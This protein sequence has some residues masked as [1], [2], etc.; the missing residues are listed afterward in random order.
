MAERYSR[1]FALPTNLYSEGSPV[2]IEAGA[3]LRDNVTGGVLAQL[4]FFSFSSKVIKAMTVGI[5]PCDIAGRR[6]SDAVMHQ[7]LDMNFGRDSEFGQ[8]NAIALPNP[9]TRSFKVYVSEAVF[10]DNSIYSAPECEWTPLNVAQAPV[11]HTVLNSDPEL[12]KQFR[13]TYDQQCTYNYVPKKERDLWFCSCQ[14]INRSSEAVCHK[15]GHK[16]LPLESI[17]I[18]ALKAARDK[19]VAEERRQAEEAAAEAER[20]RR[21]EEA[22]AREAARLAAE[23][24]KKITKRVSIITSAV[25]LVAFLVYATGWHLI[26]YIKYTNAVKAMEA[27][28]YDEAY[29]AFIALG[30]FSDSAMKAR[31]TLYKKGTSLMDSGAYAEAAAEFERIPLYKDSNDKA[32]YCRNQAAYLEAKALKDSGEYKKAADIFTSLGDY[33][34][35]KALAKESNYLY[36]DSLLNSGKYE[37]AYSAFCALGAFKKGVNVVYKDSTTKAQEAKYRYGLACFESGDYKNAVE[38]FELVGDYKEAPAKLLEA[39]YLYADNLV[40]NSDLIK[41]S[42]LYRELGD[43]KDSAELYKK[44]YYQYGLNL[45][46]KEKNYKDAVIVFSSLGN[47]EE[48]KSKLKEAKYGYVLAHKNNSDRLTYKY[49]EEL[50]DAKYKDSKE[51]YKSLYA[52]SVK[53]VAFNTDENDYKTILSSVSRKTK[54]LHFEFVIQGGPP[55]QTITLTHK[56]YWP[57]GSTRTSKWYWENERR[58]NTIGAYWD[59]GFYTGTGTMKIKVYNKKTGDFLGE[60]SIKIT[61]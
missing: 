40:G 10:G 43:Y 11:G 21:E 12:F 9:A 45:L 49:L 8:K 6:L 46:T 35:S 30:D 4:K 50:K 55:G 17:D 39:K 61:K 59:D 5:I 18:D 58:G 34:D 23:R 2:L 28:S 25:L 54:Y 19:R 26:P 15:C 48:S 31:D 51:I 20:Q 29:D 44:T 16:Y 52:W 37:E 13:M 60:A 41:A 14:A 47:Y 7:Y 32:L 57:N 56:T 3:L 38:A 24:R 33:S 22:R 42:D 36:A 27:H 1:L 53:L